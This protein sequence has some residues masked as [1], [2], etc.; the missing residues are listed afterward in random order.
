MTTRK[1]Q[2]REP[3]EPVAATD[4]HVTPATTTTAQGEESLAEYELDDG[5]TYLLSAEEAER[6]G[7]KRKAKDA[8]PNKAQSPSN[9]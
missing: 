4:P 1:R 6:R 3:E 2:I 5:S 8:P 9:K 7:A